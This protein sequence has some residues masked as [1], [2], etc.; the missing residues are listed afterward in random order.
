[1][2]QNNHEALEVSSQ[3]FDKEVAKI[4]PIAP[5]IGKDSNS[6]IQVKEISNRGHG[7]RVLFH[8]PILTEDYGV[9]PLE[10]GQKQYMYLMAD[11]VNVGE[12]SQA[13]AIR[14]EET[15]DPSVVCGMHAEAKRALVNWYVNRLTTMFFVHA[16]GYT[17]RALDNYAVLTNTTLH[18]VVCG[19]NDPIPPSSKC[20]IRPNDKTEDEG[21]DENDTFSLELIDQATGRAKFIRGAERLKPICIGGKSFYVLYLHPKQVAQLRANTEKERWRE[22]T[23]A[24]YFRNFMGHPLFE[25]ALGVY[26]GVIL[27]ETE[28]VTPGV[29]GNVHEVYRGE[30]VQEVR[31][32][33]LLG[34]QSVF[35]A[36]GD[37]HEAPRPQITE[38]VSDFNRELGLAIK[39]V[40]G[41]KKARLGDFRQDGTIGSGYDDFG[42]V[43]IPT[44]VG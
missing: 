16:C 23:R 25:G 30:S 8:W 20:V 41:M 11:S 37:G 26:N 43:V 38:E 40:I 22:I 6:I 29:Q 42:T 24:D 12:F 33:V 34:A 18:S 44:Y 31:R 14:N 21:L 7:D 13:V 2:K 35:L 4:L 28:Y 5:L 10:T 17:A 3:L 39:T 9:Y 36:F 32:A 15:A 1:M 19:Y 27:H